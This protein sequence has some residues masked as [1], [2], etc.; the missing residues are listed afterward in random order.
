MSRT[1]ASGFTVHSLHCYFVLPGNPAVP[2]LYSVDRIRDGAS[3]CTRR[4]RASQGDRT[5]F[6][7][8]A[9]FQRTA[10]TKPDVPGT[11][12]L[13]YQSNMPKVPMPE[14]LPTSTE[15]IQ[16]ALEGRDDIPKHLHSLLTQRMQEP[17]PFEFK[18][19]G[20][21][22]LSITATQ[23]VIPPR[24]L[25]WIRAR[26]KLDPD[27]ALHQAVLAHASDHYLVNTALLAHGVSFNTQPRLK[28]LASLD[29]SMWFHIPGY[30]GI[31][32]FRADDWLLYELESNRTSANRGLV[33]GRVWTR[34]GK[35]AVTV[36]QEGVMRVG[37]D[38]PVEA[39]A[40]PELANPPSD[41]ET[42]KEAPAPTMET[43]RKV[44]Q[45]DSDIPPEYRASETRHVVA[46]RND[47]SDGDMPPEYLST[48]LSPELKSQG[49]RQSSH[50]FDG[51]DEMSWQFGGQDE[52]F[53][54]RG[55]D[56]GGDGV[57]ADMDLEM[58][59]MEWASNLMDEEEEAGEVPK[60][61]L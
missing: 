15:Q 46:P 58:G 32:G 14:E 1:V 25:V 29:H 53:S 5:I 26:G 21:D 19:V 61:K 45:Q 22:T 13:E 18:P 40:P 4:V 60:S 33:F 51:E 6:V 48:D 12:V 30:N 55:R 28:L 39:K 24:Q 54:G 42:G 41:E 2:I 17:V 7:S 52:G 57:D 38:V 49:S 47:E 10:K 36:A 59:L 20:R 8:S 43:S 35:L 37:Y 9:S 23:K 27:P 44:S 50:A 56:S 11:V 34:D 16:K 31:T 3:F